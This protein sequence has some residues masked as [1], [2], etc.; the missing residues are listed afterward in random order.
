MVWRHFKGVVV[1]SVLLAGCGEL[2]PNDTPTKVETALE[3]IDNNG[4][5]SSDGSWVWADPFNGPDSWT[6]AVPQGGG[7]DITHTSSPAVCG[8]IA[9]PGLVSER[10]AI[11][12]VDSASHYRTIELYAPGA[13]EFSTSWGNYG[14]KTFASKPACVM[15]ENESGQNN[16]DAPGFVLAGRG[17][18]TG[19]HYLYASRGIFTALGTFTPPVPLEAWARVDSNNKYDVNG[20]PSVATDGVNAVGSNLVMVVMGDDNRTIY[21]YVRSLPY[22]SHSWSARITG[23][24]L[25]TGTTAV[26]APSID[27]IQGFVYIFHIVVRA[28]TNGQTKLYETYFVADGSGLGGHF[29]DIKVHPPGFWA[30]LP[31]TGPISG[32]PVISYSPNLALYQ[33]TMNAETLFF[34]SGTQIKQTSGFASSTP[35]GT[36]PVLAIQNMGIPSVTSSPG[37][38]ADPGLERNS[39]AAVFARHNSQLFFIESTGVGNLVP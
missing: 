10:L 16:P 26:S 12:S 18:A 7:A 21:A 22:T 13:P 38:V 30:A 25:P 34:T 20:S 23:P 5:V 1:T 36:L 15:R 3:F 2:G 24:L 27:F 31:V 19:D 14:T 17:S 32:D 35:L 37:V 28:T 9:Q 8:A 39:V 6:P 29:S 33:Q 4:N 11:I